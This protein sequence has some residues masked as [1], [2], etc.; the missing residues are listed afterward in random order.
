M[1]T[2]ANSSRKT[3]VMVGI[4]FIVATLAPVLSGIFLVP[5]QNASDLLRHVATHELQ[6]MLG[7]L[8]ELMMI[9]AIVAIPVLLLP[10]LKRH[11]ETL[12]IGY[13]G[14][15]IV[16]VIPFIVGVIGLLLLPALG[17][18]S[19]QVDLSDASLP[20]LGSLLLAINDWVYV[21]GVRSFLVLLR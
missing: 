19:L 16:E 6:V 20:T 2:N 21:I 12:A 9:L 17:Q 5:L 15:R 11:N 14:F 18:Q 1:K 13:L 3:A 4:L 10:V 7:V 8:L